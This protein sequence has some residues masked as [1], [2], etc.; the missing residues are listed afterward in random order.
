[1]VRRNYSRFLVLRLG[2]KEARAEKLEQAQMVLAHV[3]EEVVGDPLAFL[4][5]L[6]L[7]AM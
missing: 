4:S 2:E 6:S 1:V 7:L 5:Q 3:V